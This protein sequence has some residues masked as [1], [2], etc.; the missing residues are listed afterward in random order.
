MSIGGGSFF[1]GWASTLDNKPN[2][3]GT[4]NSPQEILFGHVLDVD[5]TKDIGKI[6]VRLIGINKEINED[7]IQ[8][9]AYPA[10]ENILKFPIPGELVIIIQGI[11]N[12]VA[13]G[14]FITTYYYIANITSNQSITFNSD[15]YMGQTIP[16]NLADTVFTS[17]YEHRFEGKLKSPES[18]ISSGTGV[19]EKAPLKP[20]EGDFILQGRFGASVRLGSTSVDHT[21]NEWSDNGGAAG[22]PIM[23]VS[24]NRTNSSTPIMEQVNKNDSTIY[25][26]S[27]QA[28]PIEISTS[29]K[30]RTH[31]RRYDL[32]SID[33]DLFSTVSDI[34]SFVETPEEEVS[35]YRESGILSDLGTIP[36]VSGSTVY[37]LQ[38]IATL[39]TDNLVDPIQPGTSPFINNSKK[40][41]DLIYVDGQGIGKDAGKALMLLKSSAAAEGVKIVLGSGYRPQFGSNFTGR[42]SKGFA[43]AFTTQETLRR[44]KSRWNNAERN[45]VVNGNPK[46][47]TDTDFI[48]KAGG[49]AFSPQTA[50]P[51]SSKHGDG[52]A[53]DLNVG[54]RKYFGA[55]LN[56]TNY[57]WMIKNGYKFGFVRTVS[58][59]EWHFE[60]QPELAKRGPYGGISEALK[61]K[62]KRNSLLFFTD[63]QLDNL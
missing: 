23:I 54:S 37:T 24:A 9:F 30:L 7:N 41:I 32:N 39:V 63:L 29:K 42:S 51:G 33:G 2:L 44:D 27:S 1:K 17:E 35:F 15:P 40:S 10:D 46:Y 34:T 31:L 55:N 52:I 38:N 50:P 62:S 43:V 56:S 4:G 28:I 60:Y 59:E 53:A 8:V 21:T 48:F 14:R 25:L 49:S 45:A 6:R 57:T 20:Y 11:K 18:F 26:C 47:T 58:S 61:N 13:L 19:K 36:Q 5:Y 16:A 12:E 3:G 22:N